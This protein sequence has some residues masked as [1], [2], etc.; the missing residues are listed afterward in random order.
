MEFTRL[1]YLKTAK[2]APGGDLMAPFWAL[3]KQVEAS[4]LDP[5]LRELIAVR[6]SQLNGCAYCVETH[7]LRALELGVPP[8]KLATVAHAAR[9]ARFSPAEGAALAWAEALTRVATSPIP[10]SV[11]Q[12]LAASF[13]PEQ[14]VVLTNWICLM[15]SWNRFNEG[16]G[17][18]P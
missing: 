17:L 4:D 15:N 10:D 9:L 8:K 13:T 11:Y 5:G 6:I 14:Q 3:K 18:L 2:E 1:D 16:F 12:D 7:S